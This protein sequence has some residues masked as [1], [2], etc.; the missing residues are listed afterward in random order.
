MW[1]AH[2]GN[3]ELRITP[4]ADRW[5]P[6]RR[7]GASS[8]ASR[9]LEHCRRLVASNRNSLRSDSSSMARSSDGARGSLFLGILAFRL[10]NALLVQTHF[11]PD[12]AWQCL[13]P[14]HLLA[15]GIGAHPSIARAPACS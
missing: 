8:I 9:A 7:G 14:A 1:D 11:E 2:E 3:C 5:R 6:G 12:E 15:F 13:E 4:L 10:I